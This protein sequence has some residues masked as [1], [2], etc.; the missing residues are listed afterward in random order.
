MSESTVFFHYMTLE[1][2]GRVAIAYKYCLDDHTLYFA[3]A[4]C[5]PHD[6]FVK[7]T[8]R[9][10]STQRLVDSNTYQSIYVPHDKGRCPKRSELIAIMYME[11]EKLLTLKCY[12]DDRR[13]M[14]I[15]HWFNEDSFVE[16]DPMTNYNLDDVQHID[17]FK[18]VDGM[19]KSIVS[20]LQC[21]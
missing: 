8:A 15:P 18:Q 21:K 7:Q 5:S 10:I 1:N 16:I 11:I 9:N 13:R 12:M 3:F 19:F 4:F 6:R 17:E 2:K 20:N 14:K